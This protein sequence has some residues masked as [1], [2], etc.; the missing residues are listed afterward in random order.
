MCTYVKILILIDCCT[1]FKLFFH[2]LTELYGFDW[3]ADMLQ[4]YE[5]LQSQ[6]INTSVLA[7]VFENIE[8]ESVPVNLRYTIKT[9]YAIGS[10]LIDSNYAAPSNFSDILINNIPFVA[11]QTCVDDSFISQ[12]ASNYTPKQ[13]V[14]V[15]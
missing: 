3:E 13:T 12:V 15:R 8:G 6:D 14:M 11:L 9:S 2:T 10:S 5:T 4:N 1:S 7:V